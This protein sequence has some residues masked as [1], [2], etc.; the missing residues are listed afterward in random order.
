M[1]NTKKLT[2]LSLCTGY[3]GLDLGLSRAVGITQLLCYVEIESFAIHNLVK[4]IEAGHLPC[5][6]LYTDIKTF[7]WGIF[8][9]KVD[10]I[11]GGFPC[12]PFSTAGKQ[13]GDTDPRHLWPYIYNG[14]KQC[15]KP[16]LVFL[17]NVAGIINAKLKGDKWSDPA[18][19]SVLHHVLRELERLGYQAEA[20]IFSAVEVG[21]PHQRKRV[22]I[23]A[24]RADVTAA[25]K[26]TINK[27]LGYT[28]GKGFQGQAE[29]KLQ[30]QGLWGFIA[31]SNTQ[32]P[33]SRG[34]QQHTWEAPRIIEHIKP[35]VGRA[36]DGFA[37]G[38]GDAKLYTAVE[39]KVDELRLLGNGVVP[40]TAEKAFRTLWKKI[41]D[42]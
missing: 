36:T 39:N 35:K 11:T 15:G 1:D 12:Q 41:T 4:K 23:L 22:F 20:G 34:E 21:A 2:H 3:G 6:P 30:K 5:A 10:I 42:T 17:E 40:D 9:K 38:V 7:D 18:G 8:N 24:C 16:A 28:N 27:K 19:I 13:G 33:S 31:G 26:E 25:F 37:G 14:L 29:S 32:Y